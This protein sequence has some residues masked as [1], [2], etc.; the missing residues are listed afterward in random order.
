MAALAAAQADQTSSDHRNGQEMMGVR[1]GSEDIL[2]CFSVHPDNCYGRGEKK[3]RTKLILTLFCIL[4][5]HDTD[6]RHVCTDPEGGD[7]SW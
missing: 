1:G 3:K 4:K 7:R 2:H 5:L 6:V